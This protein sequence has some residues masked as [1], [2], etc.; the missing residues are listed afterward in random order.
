MDPQQPQGD[1]SMAWQAPPEEQGPAPGVRFAGHG[2]RLIAY[3]LDSIV[4]GIVIVVLS[5]VFVA[6]AIGTAAS[7]SM[8]AMAGGLFLFVI[9]IL[10]V[11]FAYFPFFWARGGQT[12]GMMPFR[13]RIVRDADGGPITGGQAVMRFVGYWINSIVFYVGFAW[14]LVDRRRRGWHDLIAGTVVIEDPR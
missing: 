1:P 6:F 10:V 2:A 7:D 13:I 11:S 5:F 14:I 9:L 8:G 4:L 3:I 12:P